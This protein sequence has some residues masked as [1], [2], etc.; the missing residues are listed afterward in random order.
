VR[1]QSKSVEPALDFDAVAAFTAVVD[2]RGF[3]AAG[4]RLGLARAAVSKRV[5]RLESAAGVRL[6]ERTTRR[7]ALTEAGAALYARCANVLGALAEAE[8]ELASFRGAPRGTV[9]LSAPYGFGATHIAALAPDLLALHPDLRVDVTLGDRFVNLLEEGFDVAVRIS[10]ARL[11]DSSLVAR[12]VGSL[13]VLTCAAPVYLAKRG[14]PESPRDLL[15]H[16]CLRFS[17]MPTR[18]EWTFAGRRGTPFSVEVAG[19]IVVNDGDALL[20]AA[21][22]GAGVAK[23]PA[24]LARDA[25]ATGALR[26]VLAAHRQP[27]LGVYLVFAGGR[28]PQ[29][30]VRAVVDF[31]A[32]R[33][34]ERLAALASD[35]TG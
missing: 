17:L 4:K 7:V 19:R 18:A 5:A 22:A 25:L 16:E 14:T 27:D 31:F 1:R 21:V 23:L 3:A 28:A 9:R 13:P 33:L 10:S 12:R 32:E 15:A 24:F 34:P 35:V 6:L 8:G 11:D 2:H 20:A 30:K 29:P 26:E